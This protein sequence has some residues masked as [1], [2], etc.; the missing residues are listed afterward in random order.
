[1]AYR[2]LFDPAARPAPFVGASPQRVGDRTRNVAYVYDDKV[3]LAVNLALAT[4]RPL[5]VRGPSGVGKSALARDVAARTGRRFVEVQMTS[6][7]EAQDLLWHFDA[8]RRLQDAQ[9]NRMADDAAYVRPG[10]LWTAL[11]GASADRQARLYERGEGRPDAGETGQGETG[12]GAVLLIDEIDKADPD[13]PNNLL[14]VLGNLAFRVEPLG[15][16]VA[17]TQP[18]LVVI[19][20]NEERDLPAAFVR[21]CVELALACPDAAGLCA[22]ARV[23]FPAADPDLL[24]RLAGHAAQAMGRS[25]VSTAEFLDLVQACIELGLDA[26]DP[27]FQAVIGATM[28]KSRG[29]GAT[30]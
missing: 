7:T 16:E 4:G 9:V 25:G 6:R 17:A 30:G 10:P 5:L 11:D 3:V 28:A 29:V 8:L 27:A 21:R 26:D 18:P 13:V 23:H 12:E 19:T 24:D 20:T 15:R 14:A 22:M 1:V 2:K